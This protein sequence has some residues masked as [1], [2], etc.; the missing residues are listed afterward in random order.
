MTKYL[1][2]AVFGTG[3]VF[4]MMVLSAF[5]AYL[6]RLVLARN[7]TVEEYGLFYAVFS[8]VSL[9]WL[10][11]GL[12]LGEALAKYIPEFRI[13]KNYD[14]IKKA[15]LSSLLLQLISAG[16]LSLLIIL[17]SDYFSK[18]Y[19]KDYQVKY[20]LIVLAIY[21]FIKP[22]TF[23]CTSTFQGFQN[24]KLYSSVDFVRSVLVFLFVLVGFVIIKNPLVPAFAYLLTGLILPLVFFPLMVKFTFKNYFNIKYSFEIGLVKK[25]LEFGF[26]VMVGSM[27]WFLI[28][29]TDTIMLTFF[30]SVQ[31]VGLYNA[32][33][34]TSNILQ[35]FGLSLT[36]VL[37]PMASEMWARKHKMQLITGTKLLYKYCFF[38]II[39][40]SLMMFSFPEIILTLLFGPSY[41]SASNA[42]KVLAIGT[43]FFIIAGINFSILSGI[44]KPKI[45]LKIIT[46]AAFFNII[47]N[48]LLIPQWSIIGAALSSTLSFFIMFVLSLFFIKKSIDIKMP[49]LVWSKIVILGIIFVF[50]IRY[51]G[52]LLESTLLNA[53]LVCLIAWIAYIALSFSLN[54][55]SVLEIKKIL[56][57][58]NY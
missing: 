25:L 31:E 19:F 29:Y 35:Y 33:L 9:L 45:N 22:F 57:N 36:V 52:Q 14:L 7:L 10:F 43:I 18:N 37:I 54:V 4:G 17:L 11:K 30:K 50:I 40:F 32:A 20:I 26:P 46:S 15:I 13:K 12:G 53:I 23:L 56:K 39:P 6:F 58:I 38:I 16:I 3:I 41:V 24:M 27:G 8:F 21:I 34:P 51:I 48:I 55:I 42:L 1:K 5:F 49:I 44:G 2:K 28:S 47:M